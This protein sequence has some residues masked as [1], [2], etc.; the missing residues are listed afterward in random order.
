MIEGPQGSLYMW[1]LK[2]I[3]DNLRPFSYLKL[4]E[5][6][7]WSVVLISPPIWALQIIGHL[8]ISTYM[9][10]TDYRLS[11]SS[12]YMSIIDHRSSLYLNLY[13]WYR[14][15]FNPI[16]YRTSQPCLAETISTI[17]F[18]RDCTYALSLFNA[19]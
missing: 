6:H 12:T 1:I 4:Y 15:F 5:C 16:R 13:E 10:I 8:Y 9:S 18:I 14:S 19:Y 2:H 3:H 7:R 17:G 11:S